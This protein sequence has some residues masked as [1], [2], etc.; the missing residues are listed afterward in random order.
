MP[1]GFRVVVSHD[2]QVSGCG[3]KA[4]GFGVKDLWVGGI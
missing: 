1:C 3:F 4:S 2:L